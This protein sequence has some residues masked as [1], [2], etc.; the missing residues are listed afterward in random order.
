MRQ[1]TLCLPYYMNAG[2]LRLQFERIRGYSAAI[3]AD[4]A[5][6]VVDDGS[7]DGDALAEPIGCP[8]SIFKVLVDVRWNQDA[9]RN[10]AAHHA[11]TPWLLLT[12][13][14]HLVPQQTMATL[15]ATSRPARFVYRFERRT[16]ERDGAVSKYKPHPNSWLLTREMFER[17]GGYDER[18]AGLYGTDAEFRDRVNQQAK[19]VMLP[20]WLIRVPRQ[21]VPDA[22]T[23]TYGRKEPMDSFGIPQVTAARAAEGAWA[24]R[25]LSFPYEK[26]FECLC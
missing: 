16:L 24:P 17:I 6:I 2:M 14:D 3:L 21:I 25:R 1:L 19:I 20:Q 8:L 23:T 11:T 10:I 15:I 22:S 9:A 5:V 12:D 13:I 4:L 26:I 7:P 18:Y